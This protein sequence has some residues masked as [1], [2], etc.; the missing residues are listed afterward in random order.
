[1]ASE[2]DIISRESGGNPYIGYGGVDLSQAPRDKYGFPIWEGKMGP[3]GISHAAGLYQFEP[4]TWAEGAAALGV[5]DFSPQSQKQVY[6]YTRAKYGDAP[7]AASEPGHRPEGYYNGALHVTVHPQPEMVNPDTGNALL[8]YLLAQHV[9]PETQRDTGNDILN[10]ILRS[11]IWGS[12]TP[13]PA[14]KPIELKGLAAATPPPQLPATV[15]ELQAGPVP[16]TAPLQQIAVPAPARALPSVHYPPRGDDNVKAPPPIGKPLTPIVPP[17]ERLPAPLPPAQRYLPDELIE[18]PTAPSTQASA[19]PPPMLPARSPQQAARPVIQPTGKPVQASVVPSWLAD[20]GNSLLNT[21]IKGAHGLIESPAQAAKEQP[22]AVTRPTPTQTSGALDRILSGIGLVPPATTDVQQAQSEQQAAQQ[23]PQPLVGVGE[24]GE[25]TGRIPE[26]A[27]NV[28]PYIAGGAPGGSAVTSAGMRLPGRIG[29]AGEAPRIEPTIGRAAEA[30]RV[31][32]PTG[33]KPPTEPPEMPPPAK[34]PPPPGAKVEA[35]ALDDDLFRAAQAGEADRLEAQKLVEKLPDEL[36]GEAD[37]RAYHE[38]ESRMTGKPTPP[39]STTQRIDRSLKPL[40]DQIHRDATWLREHAPDIYSEMPEMPLRTA[41]GGYVHRKVTGMRPPGEPLDPTQ[42]EIIAGVGG[43]GGLSRR[44]SGMMHRERHYL[45]ENNQGGTLSKWGKLGEKLPGGTSVDHYGQTFADQ[46]GVKWTAREPTTRELEQRFPNRN[47]I[48]SLLGNTIDNSLRLARVRRNV[49][50]LEKWKPRLQ[51]AGHWAPDGSQSNILR[52]WK[53]VEVPQ[54]RGW[55][56]PH[57]AA[58]LNDLYRSDPGGVM[59]WLAKAN[60]YIIGSMFTLPVRHQLNVAAHYA[61]GRGFDNVYR[62]PMLARAYT[63]VATQ[64]PNYLRYLRAGAGM[65]YASTLNEN[66][67]NT[68]LSKL[69][70]DQMTQ[71]EWQGIAK[72]LGYKVADL[73]RAEYAWSR[74]ALWKVNDLFLTARIM[75][76]EH[77]GK[78]LNEAIRVAEQEIPNYRLPASNLILRHLINSPFV[79]FGRY[80]YGRARALADTVKN[81]VGPNATG[82]ER[83]HAIGQ[84]VVMAVVGTEGYKVGN[85]AL[86]TAQSQIS[87]RLGP[88]WGSRIAGDPQNKPLVMSNYGPFGPLRAGATL[89][90][91]ALG[92]NDDEKNWAQALGSVIDAT[93]TRAPA[94]ELAI[95]LAANRDLFTGEPIFDPNASGLGNVLM[96]GKYLLGQAFNP[97]QLAINAQRKGL[98]PGIGP[99]LGFQQQYTGPPPKVERYLKRKAA[100]REARDPVVGGAKKLLQ[101]SPPAERNDPGTREDRKAREEKARKDRKAR[102][103]GDAR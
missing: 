10:G 20:T 37:E 15:P 7:W 33:G 21:I 88:T 80:G 73:V 43:G 92:L 47:Y 34:L 90:R 60:K 42:G 8:S 25:L 26:L 63:E 4:H 35:Q 59:S 39:S 31:E 61:V 100:R 96:G 66:F 14:F 102:E 29:R 11:S 48:K 72:E 22:Q 18:P 9:P 84:A 50:I 53:R 6:D 97:A 12:P 95:E 58:V 28:L 87:Q 5:K 32:P 27:E 89:A 52:N 71:P 30:P 1:M 99:Q 40:D 46:N 41:E 69:F 81:L 49:E 62:N 91:A 79:A 13:A 2:Q 85:A 74:K 93:V 44:A 98:L 64:G 19:A 68:M 86:Q 54:I 55:A 76:L 57:I 51:E 77:A 16:T 36:K 101:P 45:W 103:G 82:E 65:R 70:H 83:L 38:R 3:A 94:P 17:S 23:P 75:E 56:E 78:P 67:Y 24:G